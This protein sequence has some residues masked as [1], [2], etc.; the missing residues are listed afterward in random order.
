MIIDLLITIGL[1]V[2][3]M[4]LGKIVILFRE[5]YLT[6]VSPFPEYVVA[7]HRF[8]IIEDFGCIE[9]TWNTP[10]AYVLVGSWPLIITVVSLLWRQVVVRPPIA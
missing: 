9:A 10:L 3:S 4:A 8:N 5:I 1:P 2:L 7:G 6:H